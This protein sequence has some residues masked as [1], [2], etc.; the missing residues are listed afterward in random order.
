MDRGFLNGVIFLDLQKAFDCVDHEILFN[1][2]TLYGCNELS[3]QWF[4][5]FLQIVLKCVKLLK[6]CPLLLLLLVEFLRGLTWVHYSNL[7]LFT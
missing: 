6:Q 5:S 7:V 4:R 1:K 3:L 2:L